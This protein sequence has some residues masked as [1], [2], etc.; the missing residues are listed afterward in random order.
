MSPERQA[1]LAQLIAHRYLVKW[2]K[3][4]FWGIVMLILLGFVAFILIGVT[5]SGAE[6]SEDIGVPAAIAGGCL[7]IAAPLVYFAFKI[8]RNIDTHALVVALSATPPDAVAL[9]RKMVG[10]SGD[11]L[12][13]TRT[14]LEPGVKFQ[15]VSTGKKYTVAIGDDAVVEEFLAWIPPQPSA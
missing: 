15:V 12:L 10:T 7:A 13:S 9:T 3:L 6:G 4:R 2:K 5:V 11:G 14:R 1:Q 8:V